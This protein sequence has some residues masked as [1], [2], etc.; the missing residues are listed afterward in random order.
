MQHVLLGIDKIVRSDGTEWTEGYDSSP[1]G[2]IA[3]FAMSSVPDEWL[4]CNGATY[5]STSN[6][7]F[8]DLY[9][10]IGTIWGGSGASS[11]KVPDLRGEFLRGWDAGKGVDSG[12]SLASRQSDAF[13]SHGHNIHGGY[14]DK[15]GKPIPDWFGGSG[16]AWGLLETTYNP[17]PDGQ[18]AGNT[19]IYDKYISK[20]GDNETRPRNVAVFYC[21]KYKRFG[22]QQAKIDDLEARLIAL[23]AKVPP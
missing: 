11:F 3:P 4:A 18:G 16:S 7:E 6:P 9:A 12:R 13:K 8:A 21:I 23:E 1:I 2:M 5:N 22:S 15:Y 20:V 17:P 10:A 19:G 14:G